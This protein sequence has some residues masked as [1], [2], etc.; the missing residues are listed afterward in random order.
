MIQIDIARQTK[1]AQRT[2]FLS[3]ATEKICE[4]VSALDIRKLVNSFYRTQH[5]ILVDDK[6]LSNTLKRKLVND[7]VTEFISFL[8]LDNELIIEFKDATNTLVNKESVEIGEDI[9]IKICEIL[10]RHTHIS[11]LWGSLTGVHPQKP[12]LNSMLNNYKKG[13]LEDDIYLELDKELEGYSTRY[14][15]DESKRKLVK[16]VAKKEFQVLHKKVTPNQLM[17]GYSLYIGIPFCP[18]TCI[19]CS[20]ASYS[21]NEYGYLMQSYL[22]TLLDELKIISQLMDKAPTSIYIGGGTPTALDENQL[23]ILLKAVNNYFETDKVLEF[24]VE[25]G[26]PDSIN[27]KKLQIM[28]DNSVTRISIN[29]QTMNQNTLNIIGRK[30]SVEDIKKVLVMARQIGFDNINMDTIMGL[31]GETNEDVMN[32]MKEIFELK[33]ESI[34]VHTLALKRSAMLNKNIKMYE[35]NIGQDVSKMLDLAY[36]SLYKNDYEPYYLYRQKNMANG[37]ENT[38]FS[39]EGFECIYNIVTMEE[40]QTIVAAGAGTISKKVYSDGKI[41]RCDNVKDVKL[42]IDKRDE[43]LERKRLFLKNQ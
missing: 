31:P 27:K 25:A 7:K 4:G 14:N 1:D 12:L 34:T 32:T 10:S 28:K 30:H 11:L 21:V 15:I 37:L 24:T 29:P 20:F 22:E 39:K 35:K 9:Q 2:Y 8:F 38:G 26:R 23:D 36:D 33:P 16:K 18:T 40:V 43:M 17:D 5:V 6:E 19:Y 3:N 13:L 42:Y 41:E